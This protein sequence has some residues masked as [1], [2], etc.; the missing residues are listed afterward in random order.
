MK[1]L[2]ITALPPLKAPEADHAFGLCERMADRGVD[3]HVI[4]QRGSTAPTHPRLTIHPIMRSW[5][6]RELPR[7]ARFMRRCA[8]DAILLNFIY[9]VYD[10][11][12]V[13]FLST[14]AK[15]RCPG[16]PF[17]ALFEDA[18]EVPKEYPLLARVVRKAVKHWAGPTQV[19]YSF[20]TLLRDSDRVIV[21]SDRIRAALAEHDPAVDG[22][23]VLIPP[24]SLLR[25]CPDEQGIVRERKRASLGVADGD[26]VLIFFGYI[27]RSKRL[28]DLLTA[29]QM[30]CER[31][32]N[33]RLLISGGTLPIALSYAA[34][35]RAMAQ[36]MGLADKIIWT[37]GFEW[38]S[39]EPSH[40]LHA[41]DLC[42]LPFDTGV[43]I[44]N[45]SFAA[46]AAHRLPTITTRGE[47]LEEPFVH[48]DNVYLCPPGDAGALAAAIELL[49]EQPKLR[50]RLSSG[51]V[52]LAE[53]WLSWERA[54]QR[55]VAALFGEAL[56]QT[57]QS[58]HC[59]G[60]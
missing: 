24:P 17:V 45:S 51:V 20:G 40:C 44:H 10:H 7:L 38:D 5:S 42:V 36:Q 1:V 52:R 34:H 43:S 25:F 21:V 31:R 57:S 54:T 47:T 30:V 49:I 15:R 55:T 13:T 58:R 32:G 11:P 35:I 48:N 60:V 41:A 33:M 27:N 12:M 37:G 18:V 50:E 9:W 29:F 3:V 23:T 22:K 56:P 4:A 16:V 39:E 59:A 28:E 6:W 2:V 53:E 26:I 46:A 8:P 14:I 19:N